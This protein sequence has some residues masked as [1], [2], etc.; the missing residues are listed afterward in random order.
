MSWHT[1]ALCAFDLET[2]SPDPLDARIVTANITLIQGNAFKVNNWVLLPVRPIPDEAAEIHG[3]TTEKAREKGVDPAGAVKEMT[4]LLADAVALGAPIV[5]FNAPYDLTVIDREAERHGVPSLLDRCGDD[6]LTLHVVDPLILDKAVDRYRKGKRTLT[7]TCGHYGVQLDDAHDASHDAMAAA[8]LAWVIAARYPRIAAMTLPE[9]H[10]FQANAKR[11]QDRS[12]ANYLR[13]LAART[14]DL[15]EQIAL[16]VRAES[17][18]GNWPMI[19]AKPKG[20][21]A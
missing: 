10:A 4:A 2:D 8:R 14:S 7:A 12:F 21:M 13:G 15:D 20:A 19:P 17:C 3:W 18:R 9:L 5:A 11:E 6:S 1:G 16:N